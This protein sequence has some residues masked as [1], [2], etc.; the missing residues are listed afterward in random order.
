MRELFWWMTDEEF[1]QLA[2]EVQTGVA[3]IPV[4]LEA[5]E[6]SDGS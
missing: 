1:S 3:S 5:S 2:R 4:V 6:E